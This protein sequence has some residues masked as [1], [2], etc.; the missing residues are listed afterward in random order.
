MLAVCGVRYACG[1]RA[2]HWNMGRPSQGPHLKETSSPLPGSNI[3]SSVGRVWYPR[4]SNSAYR[5]ALLD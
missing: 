4:A 2:S 5:E 1:W 3:G